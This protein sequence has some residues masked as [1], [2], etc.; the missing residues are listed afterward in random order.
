MVGSGP[1]Q[2]N[3]RQ[4]GPQWIEPIRSQQ[5]GNFFVPNHEQNQENVR[6][7]KRSVNTTQTS[8]NHSQVG[9][10]ISQR[11][12]DN[13]TIQ[14]EIDDLKKKL[15]HAQRRRSHSSSDISS[16]DEEDNNYNQRSIT[17]PSETFSYEDEHHHRRKHEGPSSRGLGNDAMSKALDQISKS[18][19]THKIEKARLPRQF[20]QLTFTLYNIRTDPV[21]HVS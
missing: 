9:S 15:R 19:F 1:H 2:E 6:N 14:Q 4:A 7:R 8:K 5:Q 3:P 13:Q 16:N 17:P 10:C 11:Q 18:P 21:E 12:N 20:H